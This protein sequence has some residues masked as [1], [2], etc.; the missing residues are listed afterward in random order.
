MSHKPEVQGCSYFHL[1]SAGSGPFDELFLCFHECD[2]LHLPRWIYWVDSGGKWSTTQKLPFVLPTSPSSAASSN[3]LLSPRVVWT[4]L[5]LDT[6]CSP[7]GKAL[8]TSCLKFSFSN[9]NSW[10]SF[11][12]TQAEINLPLSLRR[13]ICVSISTDHC[14]PYAVIDLCIPHRY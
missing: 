3:Y 2:L 14:Q 5:S 4:F 8:F 12:I 9:H 13:T 7:S 6:I 10:K 1:W 11:Q